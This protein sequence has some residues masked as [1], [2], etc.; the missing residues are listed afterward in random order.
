MEN[1]GSVHVAF[2]FTY[3]FVIPSEMSEFEMRG[4]NCLILII[5]VACAYL[6][7]DQFDLFGNWLLMLPKISLQRFCNV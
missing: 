5:C 7:E 2:Y 4:R 1:D 6:T 3:L